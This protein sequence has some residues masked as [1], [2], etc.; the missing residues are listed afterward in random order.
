MDKNEEKDKEVDYADEEH[1]VARYPF[2][3]L[4]IYL[5]IYLYLDTWVKR[6]TRNI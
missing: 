5:T 4:N 1:K 6:S 2:F 3:Y